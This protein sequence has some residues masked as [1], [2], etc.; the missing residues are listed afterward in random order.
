MHRAPTSDL[1]QIEDTQA[2]SLTASQRHP[3]LQCARCIRAASIRLHRI[4]LLA[5]TSRWIR[6][7]VGREREVEQGLQGRGGGRCGEEWKKVEREREKQSDEGLKASC[8]LLA[9]S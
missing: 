5:T 3:S 8:L 4:F 2:P 7:V 6:K 9:C 1:P